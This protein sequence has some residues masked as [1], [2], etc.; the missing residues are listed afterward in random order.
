MEITVEFTRVRICQGSGLRSIGEVLHSSLI[1][2]TEAHAEKVPRSFG[3]QF[4]R[5]RFDETS[6]YARF[7]VRSCDL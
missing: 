7:R 1:S 2:F 3:R 4:I 5:L 6:P